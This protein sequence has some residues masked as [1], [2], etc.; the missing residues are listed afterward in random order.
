MSV[1]LELSV[2]QEPS[3]DHGYVAGIAVTDEL[4]VVAG[5]T[6]SETP[7]LLA[8]SNA[9]HFEVRKTPRQLGLRNVLAAG[10][11]VWTCGEYGQLAVSRDNG[12]TWKLFDAGT[13][14]CLFGLA[15]TT[16]GA[17]WV[18]GDRGYAARVIGDRLERIDFATTTRFVAV[19]ALSGEVVVLGADGAL[20]RWREGAVKRVATGAPKPLTALAITKLGTW[21]V[22]G[23]GGFISRSPDGAWFSRV[24][25][26]VDV[27]L[28]GVAVCAGGPLV[29][30]GDRGIILISTDDG[31][32]WSSIPTNVTAHLWSVEGFGAGVLI[33]GDA[34]MIAKLAPPGDPTWQDRINVFG[35][36]KPLDVVFANGP[37]GFVESGLVAYL[38]AIEHTEHE[39]E[40]THEVMAGEVD[41]TFDDEDDEEEPEDVERESA[42]TQE[43]QTEAPSGREAFAALTEPGTPR[44]FAKNYGVPMPPEVAAFVAAIDGRDKWSSFCELRLDADLLPDVG[45]RNLFELIVLRDQHAYLG[46]GL[47]EALCG[48]F[49]FGSQDNGDTYHMEL[50]EWDG[51]RQVLHYDHETHAYTGVFADSLDSLIYLAALKLAHERTKIS[52]EAFAIGLRKLHGKIAPTWHFSIEDDD[53][54]FVAL[55][56]KRR[57][58]EFFFYRSRWI[59]ALLKNDGVT[60]VEDIPRLFNADFNQ[61]VP[62]DQLPARYEACEKLI[63]T[64]LYSMW[65]AFLFD[66]PELVPYLE[67]GRRHPSRLVRDAAELI[68]ELRGG[69]NELGTIKDVAAHLAAFRALDLDPRRADARKAEAE[70][71]VKLAR[72]RTEDV[73]AELARTPQAGWTELA[74]R[75]LDDGVAHRALLARFDAAPELAAQLTALGELGEMPDVDREV[76]LPQLATSLGSE[77]EAVLVGSLVRDDQLADALAPVSSANGNGHNGHGES[78]DDDDDSSPGWDAIDR[79][80][81]PIYG[82]AEPHA[83]Y[84]TVLPY[85][86]GGNDPIHGISV[87]LR[88]D[89]IPHFHFVTYGFTDLFVKETDDPDESGFGF[90]LTLRLGR[91]ADENEVPSWALN[92]L[93]NL[94]RYV[95]GTGNRFGA[96]HKM[97]L[98]GPI[99]L[100][101]DTKLTAILF[102][103]DP[104]LGAFESEFG[105]AHFIQ[106]VGITDDEYRLIQEWSTTGLVDIL[107]KKLPHLVTELTRDS[108]LED[109]ILAAEVRRRVEEE[110]SSEDLTFAGEMKIDIDAPGRIRIE[111]GA[112]YAAALPRSMRGRLRHDRPYTLRGR[113]KLLRLVPGAQVGYQLE[114]DDLELALTPDVVAEIEARMRAPSGDVLAATYRFETWPQLEIVVTPSIIRDQAGRAMEVRGIVDSEK[115]RRLIDEENA[116]LDAESDD[117]DDDDDDDGGDDDGAD[118]EP[119][120]D[121]DDDD[122]D[123]APPPARVRAAL[124]MSA[125][126]L[127]L[128]PDDSEVQ[129]TH[130]MLLLDADRAGLEGKLDELVAV[131]PTFDV[132]NRINIA[133]RLG[134]Q[135][136]A[137]FADALEVVLAAPLPE[138]IIGE[139]DSELMSSYGD[140]AEELFAELGEAVLEHVPAKLAQLVPLLP[141]HVNLLSG[142]AWKA[143]QA[144]QRDHALALYDRLLAIPIPAEGDER[145]NY[146]RGLNNAC[147]Q[148]H[149]AKA[150]DLAVRIADRAQPVAHE[151]PYIYHSAACAYAAVGDYA[152]AF[153]QVKLAV[154]HNYDH[155]G[156]VEVDSDLGPILE[157]PEFKALF[158][159]WHQRQEGN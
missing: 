135:G 51:P 126:A 57:D 58:T 40:H 53:P 117:D 41:A 105:K 69:R 157:W 17:V 138:R 158:R 109:P 15:R 134:K 6:S 42:T 94:A 110:G 129:F 32:H 141:P 79:A 16:D 133:V 26:D 50:Y 38:D 27:D 132:S 146:L 13:D 29:V 83:H 18:V 99:A 130:A 77:L 20:Y 12:A 103:E 116:R 107:R 125:R 14:A 143:I 37:E 91:A 98:N 140:V 124:A 151:N 152:K 63:P 155:L 149:A 39:D 71:R 88:T 128:A 139:G 47:V 70:A 84:G 19:Y 76:A 78:D 81:A 9:R 55:D 22:V 121:D 153:E 73:L 49:C 119:V 123:A 147:V 89:P 24:K 136:H 33:G 131:L 25:S 1:D 2:L 54:E 102:T 92:F 31:R 97:G 56:A 106:V 80:L 11:A 62:Q 10:D 93:Q 111:M 72:S 95:F 120:D 144:G 43:V 7:M 66:E 96:G 23:D 34:G 115:A 145:T 101:H 5:G 114:D 74:W 156:K 67:I 60:G 148:A 150:Y 8:S 68:D 35:G 113:D 46:T 154:E 44:D 61:V 104:E 64:A 90:E 137:R 159:D 86:L 100:D 45:H 21:I 118:D 108:V 142:L 65:R 28:E 75:W 122:E 112:L 48:V 30:V 59:C 52:P 4:V 127:T 87:Y 3:D 82:D 85:M 36:A